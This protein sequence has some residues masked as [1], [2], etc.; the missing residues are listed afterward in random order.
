MSRF[1]QLLYKT[2]IALMAAV[3]LISNIFKSVIGLRVPYIFLQDH[4]SHLWFRSICLAFLVVLPFLPEIAAYFR[5]SI[6]VKVTPSG[7]GTLY[8]KLNV[9]NVGEVENFGARCEVVAQR[10]SPNRMP[11][12]TFDLKWDH[13]YQR[14]VDFGKFDS[15]NLLVAEISG[16]YDKA[17][18]LS[19]C[20]LDGESTRTRGGFS[21][22]IFGT[23]PLPEYHLVV[24]IV[25]VKGATPRKFYYTLRPA[26]DRL[27][28]ELIE[29]GNK[30]WK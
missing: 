21:W 3:L 17:N 25:G 23:M 30:A 9:E 27:S 14:R 24:T 26:Q 10:N 2:G 19:L 29:G 7:K 16:G 28:V 15:Q 4:W 5:P 22:E 20:A 8:M 13:T 11:Q 1:A 6:K 12:G 18:S